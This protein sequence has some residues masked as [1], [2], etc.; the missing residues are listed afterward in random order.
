M[1][2][3]RT[4]RRAHEATHTSCAGR[5]H[6]T[7]RAVA[8]RVQLPT[9]ETGPAP[10]HPE[11]ET[12][13]RRLQLGE[14]HGRRC[15]LMGR[16]ARRVPRGAVVHYGPRT[17]GPG[18]RLGRA[19]D[20]VR[21]YW[22]WL[23]WLADQLGGRGLLRR[24]RSP[25]RQLEKLQLGPSLGEL[26]DLAASPRG[27]AHVVCRARSRYITGSGPS[28]A[29]ADLGDRASSGAS[30]ARDASEETPA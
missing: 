29:A 13:A 2:S 8:H 14:R 12:P 28:G 17:F 26:Q 15:G 10:A 25:R 19:E 21:Q 23:P 7:S 18:C 1:G 20:V 11:P 27:V 16:R 24:S 6:S 9:W 5:G 22:L 30:G 3:C 4:S